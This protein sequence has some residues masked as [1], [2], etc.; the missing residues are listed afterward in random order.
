[1]QTLWSDVLNVGFGDMDDQH[2]VL[3]N[4]LD[5][6]VNEGQER[7]A[8]AI[9]TILAG[10]GAYVGYHFSYEEKQMDEFNYPDSAKHKKEHENFGVQVAAALEKYK[11]GEFSLDELIAFL[12]NW[13]VKHILVRDRILATYLLEQTKA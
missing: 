6:L 9:A 8:E 1:M 10:L 12:K 4:Y 5:Q 7:G 3:V 13:L 2:K 11:G